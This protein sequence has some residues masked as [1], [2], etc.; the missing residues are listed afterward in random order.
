[1][2]QVFISYSRKDIAFVDQLAADLKRAG[3]DVWYDVSGIAGGD[4]WRSEI[5]NALRTSQFVLVVLSPDAIISEWVERE[6]LFSSN[7]KRKIIPLM[8]RSCELPLNYVDLNF[9]DVQGDNYGRNFKI[10]LRAL[11]MDPSVVNV[12]PGKVKEPS[13]RP[14]Y[15]YIA[16]I[17]GGAIILALLLA[18]P[19][20]LRTFS[21]VLPEASVTLGGAAA[22][23]SPFIPVHS[24]QTSEPG[25]IPTEIL[26]ATDTSGLSSASLPSD[27]TD[28]SGVPMVLVSA[29]P[30]TMGS[31]RGD[32]DEVPIHS[33]NIDGFY[34]DKYEVTNAHY[35]DCVNANVCDQP[36]DI[37]YYVNSQYADNPVIFVDWNM[38][39]TY[40]EWRGAKL[41]TEGQ[42]EKAAR[43]GDE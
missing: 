27:M 16:L 8:Y 28:A 34:I 15:L 39:K 43:G 17:G 30:F 36:R 29:G 41:P 5:E 25:L 35:Q 24:S 18:T 11:S 38:A 22:S 42:W 21:P 7:L 10:L 13:P 37:N 6:F 40:C 14:I 23:T 31:D 1:M 4:R 33:V 12:L 3:L 32:V 26:T 9:I 2:T 20:I 19:L